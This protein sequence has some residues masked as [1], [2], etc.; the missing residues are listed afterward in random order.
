MKLKT[1]IMVLV[2]TAAI[3]GCDKFKVTTTKDG[4][5]LLV[6]EKG[7]SGK[8]G[9]DGDILTFDLVIK[10]DKDSVIK[11][12]YKEGQAFI[13]P[14]QKGQFKGSFESALYHIGE[15]DSTTVLVSSDSLFKLMNQPLAPGITKGSDLKFTVK[16][17]KV[18]TRAEFDKDLLDKKNNEPKEIEAYVAKNLK[19]AQKTVDGIYYVENTVGTGAT[20]VVGNLVNVQYVG[21]FLN[22]KVFDKSTPEN[23]FEFPVGEGR[24]IAGWDKILMTMKKGGKTTVVIPSVLAY[25]EQGVGP[26]QPNTPLVFEI[27]LNDVKQK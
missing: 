26:I 11:D 10:S 4:D 8:V 7:K 14:I 6:H 20:P 23:P 3:W 19:N 22:G 5:R 2:A 15:G 18:Q 12:S 24:V 17:H 25:G 13:M 9:K 21:K 27:T 16:M 1:S